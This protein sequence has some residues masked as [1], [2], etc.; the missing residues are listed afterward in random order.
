MLVVVAA[1]YALIVVGTYVFASGAPT[2]GGALIVNG[3]L[4]T[5]FST[6]VLCIVAVGFASL[7]GSRAAA[8]T[9]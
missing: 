4:F 6:G 3:L 2:P 1:A 9:C 7:V 8:L 5:L